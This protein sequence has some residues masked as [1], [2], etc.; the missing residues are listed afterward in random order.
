MN[1]TT[2]A[3]LRLSSL[4]K[5]HPA[6]E[7]V[8]G[9]DESGQECWQA[10]LCVEITQPMRDAGIVEVV[11]GLDYISLAEQLRRQEALLHPFSATH[12]NPLPRV[13]AM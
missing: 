2:V 11:Q 10:R 1:P 9:W 3:H 5:T 13:Y 4:R 8:R 7:F 12:L 6:Y